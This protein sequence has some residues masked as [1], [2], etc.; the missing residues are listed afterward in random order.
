M[1]PVAPS[2]CINLATIFEHSAGSQIIPGHR[3]LGVLLVPILNPRFSWQCTMRG[4]PHDNHA[5][6][7][8]PSTNHRNII[9][10]PSRWP[11]S[12]PIPVWIFY[13]NIHLP[14]NNKP[15]Y[16]RLNLNILHK[17]MFDFFFSAGKVSCSFAEN[18]MSG[19]IA[20]ER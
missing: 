19:S 17:D 5:Q 8:I 16:P 20:R 11:T 18:G 1:G 2:I 4:Q 13:P 12:H 10:M 3:G 15:Y 9:G 6:S 7:K 14:N